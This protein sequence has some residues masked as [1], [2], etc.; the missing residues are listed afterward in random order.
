M[1]DKRMDIWIQTDLKT[2]SVCTVAR[3]DHVTGACPQG[4]E[5]VAKKRISRSAGV[6]FQTHTVEVMTSTWAVSQ[7]SD[8]SRLMQGLFRGSAP[9]MGLIP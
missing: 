5:S 8:D 1:D 3:V 9:G 4:S 2:R 6:R 7:V